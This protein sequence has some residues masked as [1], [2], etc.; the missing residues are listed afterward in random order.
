L[1]TFRAI[2]RIAEGTPGSDPRSRLVNTVVTAS[3]DS[4][5]MKT[6]HINLKKQGNSD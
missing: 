5:G 6:A 4:I 3:T 2:A 1:Y